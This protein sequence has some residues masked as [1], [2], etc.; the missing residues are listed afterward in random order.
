MSTVKLKVN[1][2]DFNKS[3]EKLIYKD[4]GLCWIVIA[5][6]QFKINR[7][8]FI[9]PLYMSKNGSS[10]KVTIQA[11]NF[12]TKFSQKITLYGDAAADLL[13]TELIAS[14][15]AFCTFGKY[16]SKENRWFFNR[17]FRKF[18]LII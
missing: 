14:E 11:T 18:D 10:A 7:N 12:D 15:M 17:D 4:L 5:K 6:N 9:E 8:G 3:D 13:E 2:S 1:R 16:S